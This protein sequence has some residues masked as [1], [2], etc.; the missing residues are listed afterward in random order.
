MIGLQA[1][2]EKLGAARVAAVLARGEAAL[3]D[4]VPADVRVARE[5]GALVLSGRGLQARAIG[6]ARL[7]GLGL[8]LKGSRR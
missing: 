5:A 8:V 1:R 2:A 7:R 3:R 4:E 6:D